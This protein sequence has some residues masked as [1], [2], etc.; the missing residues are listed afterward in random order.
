MHSWCTAPTFEPA[1]LLPSSPSPSCTVLLSPWLQLDTHDAGVRHDTEIALRQELAH[2]VF[3]NL[4]SAILPVPHLAHMPSYARAMDA[5]LSSP[6]L[7]LAVRLPIYFPSSSFHAPWET[8]DLI[9]C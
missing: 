2:C 6:L 5:A 3:L 4:T 8:W 7:R 9:R 1:D